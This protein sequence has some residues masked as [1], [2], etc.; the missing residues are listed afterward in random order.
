MRA[1]GHDADNGVGPVGVSSW[2]PTQIMV[3]AVRLR[4]PSGVHCEAL[5]DKST[6]LS[7]T[8]E[9]YSRKMDSICSTNLRKWIRTN[10]IRYKSRC[11]VRTCLLVLIMFKAHI[12]VLQ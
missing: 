5:L 3:S 11:N 2:A 7:R 10:N 8:H 9:P 12:Y 4:A 6:K 1:R